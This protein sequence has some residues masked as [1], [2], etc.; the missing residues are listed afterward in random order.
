[1][2]FELSNDL[3]KLNL[4]EATRQ[5]IAQLKTTLNVYVTGYRFMPRFQ[6]TRWDGKIDFFNNGCID[7]GLWNVV[8][9]CCKQYGYPFNISNRDAFPK[10][11]SITLDDVAE[12]CEDFYKDHTDGKGGAFTP[13]DHQVEAVAAMLKHKFCCI[14]VATSGGKSLIFATTLFYLLKKNPG[15]KFLLIVPS[16]SLVT[17]FYDDIMNYNLGFN[18]ENTEP[19][20][21]RIMEVMSDKP[22]KN[23]SDNEPN[24]YIGTYQSLVNYGV[25]ENQ[26]DFYKQ[27][28]VLCIDESHKAKSVSINTIVKRS[29]GYSS[30]RFGMSG[31]Y[32]NPGSSELLSILSVTGPIVKVVK[33]KE[34]MDKGLIS[35][36]KIKCMLVNHED[37]EFANNVC[38]IKKHGN[39][40]KAYDL[41][42]EYI[43][44][45]EKRKL[46]LTKLVTRFDS[47]SLVLFHNIE[48]GT[49]LYNFFRSN[50][51]DKNFYY[52]DGATDSV[53]REYI[54]KQMENTSGKPNILVASYGTLSTGVSIKALKYMIMAQPFKSNSLIRQ[55]I[56]R[57]LRLHESKV[58][59]KAVIFDIV[60]VFH[61]KYKT[62]LYNQFL[63]RKNDIYKVQEF[64]FDETKV[65]L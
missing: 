65:T 10:D 27:F 39:G 62:I 36:A 58:D 37:I 12:F 31:T 33:A 1:M 16:V 43:Q 32:Q 22:R 4:K 7:F 11:N 30:Y 41:E 63:T 35:N 59:S 21:I 57:L 54:K 56:G 52:I 42:S 61:Y 45:S 51:Q 40:K 15:F 55:S 23:F 24:V 34:L 9:E 3:T 49:E 50:I 47:N 46:F 20:D 29:F 38:I 2:L 28:D 53:K 48:Y 60:D 8:Y 5:E 18:N 64:E 25:P 6:K 26:P 19:L 14:E 44:K 17:Q 13:Y